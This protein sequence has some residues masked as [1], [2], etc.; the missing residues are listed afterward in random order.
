MKKYLEIPVEGLRLY[1]HEKWMAYGYEIIQLFPDG[2]VY[3]YGY[4][5]DAY[6]FS[7][8]I[9]SDGKVVDINLETL[10]KGGDIKYSYAIGGQ[11]YNIEGVI[12][13]VFMLAES[14]CLADSNYVSCADVFLPPLD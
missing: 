2:R 6:L 8:D 11:M 4:V 14:V 7:F 5:N 3:V 10:R 13:G 12:V 1:V 9:E